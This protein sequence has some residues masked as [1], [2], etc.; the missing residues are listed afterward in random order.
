M[1]SPPAVSKNPPFT[2]LPS[3]A[4]EPTV[5]APPSVKVAPLD[6]ITAEASVII[7]AAPV[8]IPP[9]LIVVAP[10]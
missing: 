6:T 4:I 5:S 7:S 2:I 8:V 10:V 9:A 1:L 3:P